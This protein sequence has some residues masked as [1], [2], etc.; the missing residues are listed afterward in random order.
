MDYPAPELEA[1]IITRSREKRIRL[2]LQV[3]SSPLPCG[4]WECPSLRLFVNLWIGLM[5]CAA[6]T[7]ELT[8]EVVS[9]TLPCF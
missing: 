6:W 8:A 9:E 4:D 3:A 2:S 5:R 7:S 1:E